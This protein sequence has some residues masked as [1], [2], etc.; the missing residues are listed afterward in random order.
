MDDC[1]D[2]LRFLQVEMGSEGKVGLRGGGNWLPFSL[3][4]SICFYP[5][6]FH[7]FT[8]LFSPTPFILK[9]NLFVRIL[10]AHGTSCDDSCSLG[11]SILLH[12]AKPAMWLPMYLGYTHECRFGLRLHFLLASGGPAEPL[13]AA[14]GTHFFARHT[15][16]T[17]HVL[18]AI[19]GE[20]S[21]ATYS[22]Y[23]LFWIC[24][25]LQLAI[26][27]PLTLVNYALVMWPSLCINIKVSLF[28]DVC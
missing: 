26:H 8:F 2:G 17:F 27:S 11:L 1:S 7:P 22:S 19:N 14:G 24:Q 5:S 21:G 16:S 3:P 15:P 6:P 25:W 4:P 9:R 18:S 20:R 13:Y 28:V 10:T 23:P 12:K